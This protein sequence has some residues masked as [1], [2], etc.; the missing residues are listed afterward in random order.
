VPV[1]R[2]PVEPLQLIRAQRVAA[3]VDWGSR[4]LRPLPLRLTATREWRTVQGARREPLCA[5]KLGECLIV[6]DVFCCL[7]RA[8]R[9]AARARARAG[10]ERSA[11]TTAKLAEESSRGDAREAAGG[12]GCR[13]KGAPRT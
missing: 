3:A 10:K 11:S 5:F 2:H 12:R 7:P 1:E 4:L 13:E 9:V 6:S 8:V